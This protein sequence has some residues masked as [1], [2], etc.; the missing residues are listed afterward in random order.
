MITCDVEND[1]KVVY[2]FCK[3]SLYGTEIMSLSYYGYIWLSFIKTSD[4]SYMELELLLLLPSSL[5]SFLCHCCLFVGR[6]CSVHIICVF[7]IMH[8][9]WHTWQRVYLL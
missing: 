3:L 5:T 6:C 1:C 7:V 2:I 8:N 4:I 9:I